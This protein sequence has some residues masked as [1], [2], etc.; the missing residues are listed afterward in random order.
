MKYI[1]RKKIL[2]C[3]YCVIEGD[4]LGQ[5]LVFL[6]F[7]KK[8]GIYSVLAMPENDPLL[9]SKQELAE[10]TSKKT[11]EYV[12]KLPKSILNETISEFNYRIAL[13]SG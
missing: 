3:V 10:Y 13:K 1:K 8:T 4:R 2:G 9:M 11:I 7:D 12:Q 6:K 5:F